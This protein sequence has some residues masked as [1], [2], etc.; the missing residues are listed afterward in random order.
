MGSTGAGKTYLSK[1]LSK[2][3][4]IK[5][6]EL[7]R[8]V[9]D[10]NN[11]T[12][13]RKFGVGK[14]NWSKTTGEPYTGNWNFYTTTIDDI[15]YNVY[16]VTYEAPLAKGV[17]TPE[18]AM[19]QVYLDSAITNADVSRINEALGPN[20]QIKVLA[21][22]VQAAGFTNAYSALNTAFSEPGAYTVDW[23]GAVKQ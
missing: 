6:Y 15:A 8:I 11:L 10:Q 22:G 20:W 13:H 1:K 21:E 4:N 14:W 9:Y 2:K 5:S 17:E 7:D 16:V 3:Y 23:S 19:H 18:K 12:K